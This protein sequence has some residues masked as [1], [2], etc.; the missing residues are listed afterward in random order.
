[1]DSF[2]MALGA[3]VLD[4]LAGTSIFSTLGLKSGYWK[5]EMH[6]KSRKKSALICYSH[7]P[8]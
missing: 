8:L 5:I 3:D 6:P 7:W 4:S 1:M 2:S